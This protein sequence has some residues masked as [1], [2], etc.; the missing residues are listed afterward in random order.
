[1]RNPLI[2][3]LVLLTACGKKEDTSALFTKMD[4]EATGIGF[5]NLNEETDAENILT[6][7]YFYNGGG[8]AAGDINNDGLTDLFF[9]SN[10][11][12]NKRYLNK[13][14]FHFE[15]ISAKAGITGKSGWKTGAAMVDINGDGFLDIYVCKGR[16]VHRFC[17]QAAVMT[18]L[19]SLVAVFSMTVWSLCAWLTK[20]RSGPC[21]GKCASSQSPNSGR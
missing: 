7:E 8:V 1:M 10:Q 14:D 18:D 9:T 19:S 3:V 5:V 2:C 17:W 15:D 11:G 21:C 12:D 20:T 4:S 6:Y 13:G 16:L